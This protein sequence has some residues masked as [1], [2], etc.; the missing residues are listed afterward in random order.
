MM[1]RQQAARPNPTARGLREQ[2]ADLKLVSVPAAPADDSDARIEAAGRRFRQMTDCLGF[3]G[4]I[5]EAGA[6]LIAKQA[7]TW[8]PMLFSLY[9]AKGRLE[10]GTPERE[11]AKALYV[12]VS[13][14]IVWKHF[15]P[16]WHSYIFL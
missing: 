12:L 13:T 1:Q 14:S 7:P 8:F 16:W 15:C 6:D 10:P 2:S 4:V 3:D 9:D 11:Q 5:I